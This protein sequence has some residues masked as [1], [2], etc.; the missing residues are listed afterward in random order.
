[1]SENGEQELNAVSIGI[2]LLSAD[3]KNA[4]AHDKTNIDAIKNSLRKFGQQKPIVVGENNEIIAGNG[5][6]EAAKELGWKQISIV[7]SRLTGDD[8]TA[9]AIADNRTAELAEWDDVNLAESL[10]GLVDS[11]YEADLTGFDEKEIENILHAG[12]GADQDE[13]PVVDDGPPVTQTGDVWVCGRHRVVCGDCMDEN[14]A[15][16]ALSGTRYGVLIADPPYGM[17]LNTDFSSMN[18]VS[19]FHKGKKH[20]RV[21]GDDAKFDMRLVAGMNDG[22]DQFWFGADY[23][24]D[25]IPSGGS[26]LVWDNRIDE[27]SDRMFGS[28]FELIW[29][30]QVRKRMILR[31]KWAGFFTDGEDRDFNHPTTKSVKMVSVLIEMCTGSVYDPFLGSG[32]TLIAAEQLGRT[33]YGIEISPKYVDVICKRYTNLTGESPVRESDGAVFSELLDKEM[34]AA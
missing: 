29:S 23:Y 31:F 10:K 12:Y 30:P 21:I 33:C 22:S 9:Y 1:M 4:R 15:N 6:W 27:S 26:W 16:V 20:E 8:R 28:C 11:G 19:G 25:T 2:N 18:S 3:P 34:V 17:D 32:T 13:V 7:R 5:T 14:V 24:R